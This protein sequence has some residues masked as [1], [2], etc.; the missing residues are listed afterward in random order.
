MMGWWQDSLVITKTD[1]D[2]TSSEKI[3]ENYLSFLDKTHTHTHNKAA[4]E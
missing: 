4:H 2:G 1:S 3:D